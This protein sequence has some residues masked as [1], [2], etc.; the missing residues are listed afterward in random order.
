MTVGGMRGEKISAM[1]IAAFREEETLAYGH[2]SC[3]ACGAA[4]D[5]SHPV[6]RSATSAC[7]VPFTSL[8]PQWYGFFSEKALFPYHRCDE[9]GMLYS[10]TYF[11]NAQL[12]RLYASMPPNMVEATDSAL[13]RTQLGYFRELAKVSNLTGEL[14]EIGP[15][16]GLFAQYCVKYGS[17]AKYW[18][19]EP[20]VAAHDG[21]RANLHGAPNVISTSISDFSSV[22]DAAISTIVMI[23]VLDHMLEPVRFLRQFREKVRP[24]AIL[25]IVTHDEGSF[26]ASSLKSRWPAYCLQHPHLFRPQTMS[27]TLKAAG[28]ETVRTVRSTNYFPLTY[29]LKH[30]LYLTTRRKVD[31]PLWPSLQVPVK[32]GNIITIARPSRQPQ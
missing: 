28:F 18:M 23:H 16:I 19:F 9:C 3:P 17:F 7:D 11:T 31:L 20:N 2:R 25:L 26:M 6:V 27:K 29:L 8:Q 15:D 21:L 4:A 14:L 30:A 12:E 1:S 13:S 32:L 22:P 10:P 5:R 24:D